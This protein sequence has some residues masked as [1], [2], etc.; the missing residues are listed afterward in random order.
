MI[1]KQ[2]EVQFWNMSRQGLS[3][4]EICKKVISYSITPLTRTSD[5]S[6]Q[7]AI[8]LGTYLHVNLNQFSQFK[9]YKREHDFLRLIMQLFSFTFRNAYRCFSLDLACLILW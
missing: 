4:T 8:L 3:L 6:N 9:V 5:D 1:M 2:K 7:I